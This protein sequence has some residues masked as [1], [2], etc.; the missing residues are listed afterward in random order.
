ER[1][2]LQT[3]LA[4]RGHPIGEIDGMIGANSRQAIQAEQ[5]RL[6]LP[7]DGRAGQKLLRA[8]QSPAAAGQDTPT[9]SG[10]G[11]R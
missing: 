5:K 2:E 11:S 4:A 9:A 1:R 10:G 7:A 3:L 8:L 6:G